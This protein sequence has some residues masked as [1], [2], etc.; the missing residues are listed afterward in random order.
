MADPAP[1]RGRRALAGAVWGSAVALALAVP[2]LPPDVVMVAIW[3]TVVVQARSSGRTAAVA[4][5][6]AGGLFFG[7]AHTEP[8]FQLII[9][10][11]DDV[12][13]TALTVVLGLAL[14]VFASMRGAPDD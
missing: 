9:E 2:P 14:A 5:S 1:R 8:R 4:C 6:L 13:L 3:L 12:V 10:G 11:Q 7:Y